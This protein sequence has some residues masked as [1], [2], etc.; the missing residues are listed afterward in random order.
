[1]DESAYTSLD[2]AII[3]LTLAMV[4]WIFFGPLMVEGGETQSLIA[5][6]LGALYCFLL[7]ARMLRGGAQ[8]PIWNWLPPLW[9][10][11]RIVQSST[12]RWMVVLALAA[13]TTVGIVSV[14]PSL[15]PMLE[16]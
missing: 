16:R 3:G 11:G 6:A 1:M 15:G 14:I 7:V 8:S 13:G 9:P 12:G 5:I 4:V 2:R 10:W